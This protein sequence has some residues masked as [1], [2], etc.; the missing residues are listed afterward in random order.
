MASAPPQ[1]ASAASRTVLSECTGEVRPVHWLH[2]ARRLGLIDQ[3]L[4]P[5]QLKVIQLAT[6]AEVIAAIKDMTV[7]GAPAIGAAG[8]FAMVFA[9]DASAAAT[10]YVRPS[11]PAF[12]LVHVHFRI[13]FFFGGI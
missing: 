5:S 12:F 1:Q 6:M 9:A 11:S 7:R 2:D 3:R 4:L 10:P 13:I 8:A